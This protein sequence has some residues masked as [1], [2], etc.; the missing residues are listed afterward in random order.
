[1]TTKKSIKRWIA[2]SKSSV[3]ARCVQ[4]GELGSGKLLAIKCETFLGI[5]DLD[6]SL[7]LNEI[8]LLVTV[9]YLGK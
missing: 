3:R 9:A 4:L 2:K 8:L 1:M 5:P 7:G 6:L